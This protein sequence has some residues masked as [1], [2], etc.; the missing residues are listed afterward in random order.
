MNASQTRLHSKKFNFVLDGIPRKWKQYGLLK[1]AF[2]NTSM[3]YID[4]PYSLADQNRLARIQETKKSGQKIRSEDLEHNFI[5][6]CVIYE[7]ETKP[8]IEH[9]A[10]SR[11]D[12]FFPV[13]FTDRPLDKATAA[14][15]AMRLE[16]KNDALDVVPAE[17]TWVQSI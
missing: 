2:V 14:V 3:F 10:A 5:E 6:R 15:R 8:V 7:E 17:N 12:H 4:C 9:F 1:E 13:N 11:S 16:E